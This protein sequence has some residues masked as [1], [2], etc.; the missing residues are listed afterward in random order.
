M[1]SEWLNSVTS[2]SSSTESVTIN[3]AVSA[4]DQSQQALNGLQNFQ[5][6]FSQALNIGITSELAGSL[7]D[8]VANT[9]SLEDIS[10]DEGLA[11]LQASFLSSLQSDLFSSQSNTTAGSE[12]EASNDTD[13]VSDTASPAQGIFSQAYQFVMGDD[14]ATLD[15]LFDTVNV[16]NHIP[17]VSDI[18]ES[19]TDN[20][21]DFAASLAGGFLY[22]GPVGVAYEGIDYFVSSSTGSSMTQH[23]KNY[24]LDNWFSSEE[25]GTAEL[26]ESLVDTVEDGA[27]SFV[28]RN[29]D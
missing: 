5:S 23:V 20:H 9:F 11:Q 19:V 7:S 27:H 21:V 10:S 17:V 18:Y 4:I 1:F 28:T 2:N 12:S 8:G 22:A 6:V 13:E 26:A 29:L 14:G 15:D 3:S 25:Q 24:V 16:L